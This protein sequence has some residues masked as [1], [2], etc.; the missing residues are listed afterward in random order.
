MAGWLEYAGSANFQAYVNPVIDPRHAA[1]TQ[2][3]T[4]SAGKSDLVQAGRLRAARRMTEDGKPHDIYL[5]QYI[6]HLRM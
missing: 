3:I 1:F 6:Q 5:L 4:T 2:Q